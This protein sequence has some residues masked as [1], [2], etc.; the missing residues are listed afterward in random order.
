[1][2][3]WIKLFLLFKV[4]SPSLYIYMD[5][6]SYFILILI[7]IFKKKFARNLNHL[8]TRITTFTTV[9]RLVTMDLSMRDTTRVIKSYPKI[10]P[11]MVKNIIKFR[12]KITQWTLM[13]M[14]T[15]STTR[16]R[17]VILSSRPMHQ[18]P[19]EG[20]LSEFT[21]GACSM[22]RSQAISLQL[23]TEWERREIAIMHFWISILLRKS[24]LE[25]SSTAPR[26][27]TD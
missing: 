18:R 17:M 27:R 14:I 3:E 9:V 16:I 12:Q 5:W 19:A 1:M 20:Q 15:S 11:K 26:K 7:Y 10:M 22:T 24:Y 8:C 2:R 6:I 21:L 4:S 13:V 25:N 23:K